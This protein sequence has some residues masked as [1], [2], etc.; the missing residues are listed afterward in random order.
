MKSSL[1]K[2]L[3]VVIPFFCAGASLAHAN[4]PEPLD[5]YLAKWQF[6]VEREI[7]TLFPGQRLETPLADEYGLLDFKMLE[8]LA[9]V[10][11]SIDFGL[12]KRLVDAGLISEPISAVDWRK[13]QAIRLHVLMKMDRSLLRALHKIYTPI[14]ILYKTH[15]IPKPGLVQL[16]ES[17]L[18]CEFSLQ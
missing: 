5:R 10:A 11:N 1:R 4:E 6:F 16:V 3:L 14:E 9:Y 13:I 7:Q 17:L 15:Q 8:D 18:H 12:F 2:C